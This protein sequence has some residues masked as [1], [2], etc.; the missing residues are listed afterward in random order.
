MA[1]SRIP[2]NVVQRATGNLSGSSAAAGPSGLLAQA[3]V[4]KTPCLTCVHGVFHNDGKPLELSVP[5]GWSLNR[6]PTRHCD[7]VMLL[8][9]RHSFQ[10]LAHNSRPW[11]LFFVLK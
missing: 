3:A 1:Q 11:G 5:R 8:G 6:P 7:N 10:A 4:A 9:C 2:H